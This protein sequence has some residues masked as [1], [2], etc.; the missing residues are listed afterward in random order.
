MDM[1]KI[2]VRA[3]LER[4]V[5]NYALL[6]KIENDTADKIVSFIDLTI[7]GGDLP[8]PCGKVIAFPVPATGEQPEPAEKEP[9]SESFDDERK[10]WTEWCKNF[11]GIEF[12]DTQYR[13]LTILRALYALKINSIGELAKTP[14]DKIKKQR[15]IGKKSLAII[16]S[17]IEKN[18]SA[19]KGKAL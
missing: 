18:N 6:G 10:L 9:Y 12:G 11:K 17:V 3:D 16:R 2:Q 8:E 15:G 5:Y 14:M 19:A 13:R 4:M 1:Q 7:G